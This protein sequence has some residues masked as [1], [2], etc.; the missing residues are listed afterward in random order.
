MCGAKCDR[1]SATGRRMVGAL[2]LSGD[3]E[4]NFHGFLDRNKEWYVED[5]RVKCS[6]ILSILE[7]VALLIKA[8]S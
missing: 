5:Q 3:N 4:Q 6:L 2:Q 8:Q 7:N 1:S